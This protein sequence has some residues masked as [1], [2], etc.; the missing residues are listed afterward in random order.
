MADR[1]W[2][3]AERALARDVGTTRIPVTGERHGAD[4]AAGAFAYQCKVRRM[5]PAWLFAWLGGIVAAAGPRRT[6]VLVL[7]R[8][9]MPRA[10][11][12]VCVRWADWVDLV[13]TPSAD[14]VEP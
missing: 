6:G 8:P 3:A 9:R 4:F 7:R 5:L 12:L 13:G 14:E 11:A 1:G 2:K 10:D